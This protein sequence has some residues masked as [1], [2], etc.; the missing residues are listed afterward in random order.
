M[1]EKQNYVYTLPPH[2][3]LHKKSWDRKKIIFM[4]FHLFWY[5]RM[6][7][8]Y[9]RAYIRARRLFFRT[10]HKWQLGMGNCWRRFFLFLPKKIRMATWDG[11][12]LEMLLDSSIGYFKRK[13]SIFPSEVVCWWDGTKGTREARD[14]EFESRP[15]IFD[16][17]TL[18]P[19]EGFY[20]MLMTETFS[21]GFRV[22]S[23]ALVTRYQKPFF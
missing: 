4:P 15:T 18:V 16:K 5:G 12:L 20:P 8:G 3:N 14:P 11:E 19:G 17:N 9:E 21:L 1:R 22:P 23:K 6:R 10:W 7:R 2:K 13:I